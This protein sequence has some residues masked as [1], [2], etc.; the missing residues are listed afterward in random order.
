MAARHAIHDNHKAVASLLAAKA[1]VDV[2]VTSSVL[3]KPTYSTVVLQDA[4]GNCALHWTEELDD[5]E[6]AAVLDSWRA[7]DTGGCYRMCSNYW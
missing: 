3:P 7:A 6:V 5:C 1:V 4:Q 2:Q